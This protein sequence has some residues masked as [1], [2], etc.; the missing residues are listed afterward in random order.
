MEDSFRLVASYT[1]TP[2]NGVYEV[3]Q[4]FGVLGGY[5]R[6]TGLLFNIA[7]WILVIGKAKIY[8]REKIES[9]AVLSSI[10]RQHIVV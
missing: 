5:L 1:D 8:G 4:E 6:N 2:Y 9:P 10:Q 3:L 7:R